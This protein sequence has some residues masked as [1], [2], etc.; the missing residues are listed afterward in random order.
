MVNV[1]YDS[2]K[3]T[4]TQEKFTTGAVRGSPEGKGRY[5]LL[6]A[7]AIQRLAVHFENGA[8]LYADENWR[9]GMPLRQYLDRALR[10][11]FKFLEGQRDEDHASAAV[12]NLMALIETQEQIRRGNLPKELDN[13]PNWTEVQR[14]DFLTLLKKMRKQK[15]DSFNDVASKKLDDWE[16]GMW[17]APGKGIDLDKC[18]TIDGTH[19]LPDMHLTRNAFMDDSF[20]GD[21]HWIVRGNEIRYGITW[22]TAQESQEYTGIQRL[23][24]AIGREELVAWTPSN[25]VQ[26]VR[27]AE[28][29]D[30]HTEEK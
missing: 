22:D 6:P 15:I 1:I 5:D 16:S 3:S 10:H 20:R 8:K 21:N 4:P 19:L 9:K 23:E 12:W 14:E 27:L 7:Y 17:A 30:A 25:G 18:G 13:L 2:V 29:D 28:F 24:D 26:S 11:T